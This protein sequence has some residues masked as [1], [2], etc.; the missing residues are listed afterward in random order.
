MRR[1][2]L[3]L[4]VVGV[5][6]TGAWLLAGVSGQVTASIGSINI[7]TSASIAILALLVFA[8]VSIIVFR[9]VMG[10]VAIPRYGANWR[11]RNRLRTG[12]Q[13]VTKVLVALAAGEQG[14]A[15]K[16]A[17]RARR[18]L[19]ESPQV[20][21]LLAEASRLS[22]REDEA[23]EA[24]RA[25]VT[26]KDAKFLGLRGLLRQAVDRQDWADAL[27]IAK[28]AEA[29]HPGTSWLRHQRAELALQTE[30]WAEAL[31]L[32]GPD[33][34]RPIYFVAAADAETDP[35]RALGY[36]KQAWKAAPEF[37][38]AVLAYAN[39]L[40]AV[41][42]E[43]RAR[44]YV[45]EAWK[46]APHP[47][48][49]NFAIERESDALS[50]MQAAKR[51]V[52]RNAAH[53]ESRFLLARTA[54]DAGMLGEARRQAELAQ[55]DG[56]HQRRLCLL[57]A[58]IEEQERGDTEAGR[59][60]QRNALRAAAG[61]DPD[62]HWECSVCHSDYGSWRPKCQSCGNIGTLQWVTDGRRSGLPAIVA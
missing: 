35:V 1:V 10:L 47:D 20:L 62:P 17:M 13:A 22:G 21:L 5:I 4:V 12:D 28:Q 54:L 16:Q 46:K 37:S 50:R 19:G 59:L 52:E 23:N 42:H 55:S 27:T 15:R 44:S 53:I 38:P 26:Q 18:L 36:A 40:R 33:E 29:V 3:F 14:V 41:G 57:M 51:L 49:A 30:N 58:E 43:G 32:I 25:L 24:F 34:K 9:V 61:A 60:A 31:D 6:I 11:R 45:V 56:I 39:R 7:Q 8:I 2:L 48:L